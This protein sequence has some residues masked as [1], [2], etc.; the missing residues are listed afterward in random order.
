MLVGR[1]MLPSHI[2]DIKHSGDHGGADPEKKTKKNTYTPHTNQPAFSC[3]HTRTC[4]RPAEWTHRSLIM[5]D[6]AIAPTY[7]EVI[8]SGGGHPTPIHH[9][10]LACQQCVLL[11][12]RTSKLSFVLFIQR[13]VSHLLLL[14][15]IED[16]PYYRI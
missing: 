14:L 9:H 10:V 12:E 8:L 7:R 6:M 11:V 15:L 2:H 4:D 16:T 3:T 1:A 13:V 5:P